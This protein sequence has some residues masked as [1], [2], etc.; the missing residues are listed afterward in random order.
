MARALDNGLVA[1]DRRNWLIGKS[2]PGLPP[3]D[4]DITDV[5]TTPDGR[6]HVTV[7]AQTA[8]L[9]EGAARLEGGLLVQGEHILTIA[10]APAA[11]AAN[12]T[13]AVEPE[14]GG[15]PARGPT[16]LYLLPIL[17]GAEFSGTLSPPASTPP[18][19]S[20]TLRAS[21][22]PDG[23]THVPIER[24]RGGRLHKMRSVAAA[25]P[26]SPTAYY[27]ITGAERA[28]GDMITLLLVPLGAP[29]P[30]STGERGTI[31]TPPD[32]SRIAVR[33]AKLRQL[34]EK[35][36]IVDGF[37]TTPNDE[38]FGMATGAP[39]SQR[40]SPDPHPLAFRDEVAGIGRNRF[41]YRVRAVDAAENRSDWSAVSVPFR[42]VDT[43]A[44]GVPSLRAVPGPR[45]VR[46]VW[47]ASDDKTVTAYRLYRSASPD[48]VRDVSGMRH[49][50]DLPIDPNAR[51]PVFRPLRISMGRVRVV[52]VP[53]PSGM[54]RVAR[55][56]DAD[57]VDL[58]VGASGLTHLHQ[59]IVRSVNP[60]VTEGARARVLIRL[61]GDV[62][63][64]DR[65]PGS[66]VPL[67]VTGGQ[68]DLTFGSSPQTVVGV[69]AQRTY[70]PG[71]LR[72]PGSRIPTSLRP[73]PSSADG[74]SVV[75]PSKSRMGFRWWLSL[76]ARAASR[77]CWIPRQAGGTPLE[78]RNAQVDLDVD[79]GNAQLV[80][81][82]VDDVTAMLSDPTTMA[83]SG[84][85]R[86]LTLGPLNPFVGDGTA[87]TVSW[88]DSGGR[89]FSA[90][91]VYGE[92]ELLDQDVR[93][94]RR[95]GYRLVA[96]RTVLL[97]EDRTVHVPSEA[98]AACWT[99]C[100]DQ[101]APSFTGLEAVWL[102]AGGAPAGPGTRGERVRI[103]W[104][105]R[106]RSVA[107]VARLAGDGSRRDVGG[108]KDPVSYDPA[109]DSFVGELV[110][111]RRT[112]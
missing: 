51:P 6:M 34:A 85:G 105:T 14:H 73:R 103:R 37:E 53:A 101:L 75:S 43:S 72:P 23:G 40:P 76:P 110:E 50:A 93:G 36:I 83:Q 55:T 71:P 69:F 15:A 18:E 70:R 88:S 45:E 95:Y 33:D 96:V 112:N 41:F 27:Q 48:Q 81:V 3:M 17:P 9:P 79:L 82:A 54:P 31:Q 65:R 57:A 25:T 87:V 104:T 109:S 58:V 106:D 108:W 59:R 111:L 91:S 107:L 66:G 100:L 38:A 46:L 8:P 22:A 30:I 90:R 56:G 20:G 68:V 13:L 89:S 11:S 98:S 28:S 63:E 29:D 44:P 52:C 35:K 60:L 12:L 99:T 84:D 49:V 94:G 102:S 47:Q 10:V 97:S 92:L 21:F 5:S 86:M 16:Q 2:A 77:S 4:V 62:L 19:A 74:S 1:T 64:L 78:V 67:T 42:Q 24:L 39:I 32:Y 26:E 7:E 61:G 80:D